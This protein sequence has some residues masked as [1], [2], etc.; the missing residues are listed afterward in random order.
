MKQNDKPRQPFFA[1]LLES[2]QPEES[3]AHNIT[4]PWLDINETHKFPS[5]SDEEWD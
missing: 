1:Q 4:K 5:D 2:Q 3:Q